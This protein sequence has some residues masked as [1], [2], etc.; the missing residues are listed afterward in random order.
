[1]MLS[2]PLEP[3]GSYNYI[4]I[5]NGLSTDK[6]LLL[7]QLLVI[8]RQYKFPSVHHML[9]STFNLNMRSTSITKANFSHYTHDCVKSF[10][11]M[12]FRLNIDEQCWEQVADM[13][14]WHNSLI[15]DSNNNH[16]AAAIRSPGV[17]PVPGN[18]R[19]CS[20]GVRWRFP[21]GSRVSRLVRRLIARGVR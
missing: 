8:H 20:L 2:L 3:S 7:K 4:M 11:K 1:M 14:I 21:G 18:G 15:L 12:D 16:A 17:P 9:N 13:Y 10:I 19:L 5:Q 6:F